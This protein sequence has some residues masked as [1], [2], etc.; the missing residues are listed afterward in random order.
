MAAGTFYSV[1]GGRASSKQNYK[2]LALLG[3]SCSVSPLFSA[4]PPPHLWE[5]TYFAFFLGNMERRVRDHYLLS[6]E[7]L[8]QSVVQNGLY[9]WDREHSPPSLLQITSDI[10]FLGRGKV[11][12]FRELRHYMEEGVPSSWP[13]RIHERKLKANSTR[14]TD[15]R[16]KKRNNECSFNKVEVSLQQNIYS[17]IFYI[18]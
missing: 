6:M 9:I 13:S 11:H 8:S 7:N 4:M 14:A 1:R 15:R 17:L 3:L 5:N 2:V 16:I 10:K 12:A 18:F